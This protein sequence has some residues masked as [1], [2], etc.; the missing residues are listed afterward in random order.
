[1]T[2]DEIIHWLDLNRASLARTKR[3]WLASRIAPVS[4][5]VE[6]YYQ[7]TARTPGEAI[8]QVEAQIQAERSIDKECKMIAQ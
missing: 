8:E 7:A 2:S 3:G 6:R 1:M 4:Q 5:Y